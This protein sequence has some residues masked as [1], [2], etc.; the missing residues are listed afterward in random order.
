[1]PALH[2]W[3][4]GDRYV[5]ATGIAVGLARPVNG[6]EDGPPNEVSIYLEADFGG[7][8]MAVV[9]RMPILQALTF[10][11]ALNTAI[12]SVADSRVPDP[13]EVPPSGQ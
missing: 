11:E 13:T 8:P 6:P 7:V 1:M 2:E 5:T 9:G 12:Q 4:D 3:V 10:R